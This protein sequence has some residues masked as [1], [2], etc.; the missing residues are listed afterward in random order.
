MALGLNKIVLASA[1]TNT[2]GA[3]WQLTTVTANN[4][5]VVIPAGTYLLFPT[6]NVTIEAVSA[7]NTNTACTTPSTFSTLIGNNTGG[8][9]ISD[10]V[11]V[12]ANVT[13]ATATTVTLATVNGGQAASGTYNT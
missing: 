3:Y 9:L 8:V 7:Y 13:V 4:A 2:P 6:A 10:G 11:N 5:T 1:S 12:R